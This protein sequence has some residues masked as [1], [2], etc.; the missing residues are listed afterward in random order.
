M[1][2]REAHIKDIRQIQTVRNAVRENTL[3][4]P[5]LVTDDDCKMFITERG[6]G[7]VCEIDDHVVGFS[8]VDLKDNNIW[9]LFVHPDFDKR[10]IGRRLHDTMLNWYF[11]QTKDAVWLGT[12]PK[13]RAEGFYR[14]AGWLEIGTHGKGEI[15]FEMTYTSWT[16]R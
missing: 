11:S 16:V 2:I 13:T 1:T 14:K 3:S 4:D 12:A 6:K 5:A 8:I 9:A 10:G 7:W 15:K